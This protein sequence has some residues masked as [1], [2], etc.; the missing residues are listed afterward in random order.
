MCSFLSLDPIE[1]FL[2]YF[3]GFYEGG[4]VF[5]RV[6]AGTDVVVEVVEDF[7]GAGRG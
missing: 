1:L 3:S 5:G 7:Y 6:F 2:R 4:A